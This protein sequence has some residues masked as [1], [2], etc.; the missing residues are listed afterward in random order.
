MVVA[1]G[2]GG[3]QGAAEGQS[4]LEWARWVEE[5]KKKRGGRRRRRRGCCCWSIDFTLSCMCC[6]FLPERKEGM[7][8]GVGDAT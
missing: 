6:R 3:S 8:F 2:L 7:A 4:P 5:E 1:S